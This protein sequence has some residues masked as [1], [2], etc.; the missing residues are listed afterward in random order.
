M[1]VDGLGRFAA[2]VMNV[3]CLFVLPR[4]K[5]PG[6]ERT[7]SRIRTATRTSSKTAVRCFVGQRTRGNVVL[8]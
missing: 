7:E 8:N 3:V 6:R 2:P 5:D 1:L 4:L